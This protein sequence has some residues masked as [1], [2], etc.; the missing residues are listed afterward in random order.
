LLDPPEAK[1]QTQLDQVIALLEA[2]AE[3]QLR[4]EAR[5]VAIESRV[6]ARSV[7]SLPPPAPARP[8]SRG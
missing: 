3:A 2:I 5:L 1:E 7:A 8:A 4:L 6:A